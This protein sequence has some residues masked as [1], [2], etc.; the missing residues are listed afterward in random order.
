MIQGEIYKHNND[1]YSTFSD[2]C[3]SVLVR[4]APLKRKMIKEN[5]EPFITKQL[6]KAIMNRSKLR[7]RDTEC[8]S[9][10]N[11][12]DYKKVKNTCSNLKN[13]RKSLTLI[14]LPAKVL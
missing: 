10:E 13:S 5:Q 11:S 8:S 14:K 3:R 4:R 6:S 12:L 9:R 7:K 2:I 1:M